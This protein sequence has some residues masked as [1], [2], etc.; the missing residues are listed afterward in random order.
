MIIYF[1]SALQQ[2]HKCFINLV[3]KLIDNRSDS[4]QNLLRRYLNL[5]YAKII[6]RSF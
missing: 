1:L 6:A 3:P 5:K 4:V 2:M